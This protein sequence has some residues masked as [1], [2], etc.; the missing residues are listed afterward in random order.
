MSTKM[1]ELYRALSYGALTYEEFAEKVEALN[2]ARETG[3]A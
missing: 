1:D 2:I 3:C